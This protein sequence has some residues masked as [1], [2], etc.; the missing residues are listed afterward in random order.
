[1]IRIQNIGRDVATDIEFKTSRPVPAR[2]FGLS[3]SSS[4]PPNQVMTSGPLIDGIP[5]LGPGDSRDITWG[6]FGGLLRAVGDQPIEVDFTYRHG[7]RKLRGYSRLEVGS[8]RDTDAS[9]NPPAA[10]AKSLD[11]LAKAADVLVQYV[12]RQEQRERQPAL[13]PTEANRVDSTEPPAG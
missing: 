13:A 5:V 11:K 4:E 7:S 12:R 1:M 10:V 3:A 2:G 9:E 8:Y 6:Q